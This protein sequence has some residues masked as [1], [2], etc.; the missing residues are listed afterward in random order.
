MMKDRRFHN[1]NYSNG[2]L[3]D[4]QNNFLKRKCNDFRFNHAL[5]R[6]IKSPQTALDIENRII[7]DLIYGWNNIIWSAHDEYLLSCIRNSLTHTIN[8]ILECGSGLTTILLGIIA[9]RTGNSLWTLEHSQYW[10]QRVSNILIKYSIKSVN[11][12]ISPL[13]DYGDFYWYAPPIDIMPTRFG[14]VICDGPPGGTKGGR[15][16]LL[17]VMRSKLGKGSLILL[18]DASRKAEQ[19]VADLWNKEPGIKVRLTGIRK[20]FFKIS[21]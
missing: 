5:R 2:G 21:L 20:P 6:F 9:E 1:M 19:S 7:T 4:E 14:L 12:I 18:D 16:G 15:S 11:L 10:G 8:P 17:A 3:S 13:K